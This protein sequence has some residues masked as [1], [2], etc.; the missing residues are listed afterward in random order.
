MGA[1]LLVHPSDVLVGGEGCPKVLAD[2]AVSVDTG[3]PIPR[4]AELANARPADGRDP[5]PVR[6][7]RAEQ[8]F[9]LGAVLDGPL[10]FNPG[11]EKRGACGQL[12][13]RVY[14][15]GRGHPR[16]LYA[17]PRLQLG[18]PARH[19]RRVVDE[20]LL[21]VRR[22]RGEPQAEAS[23]EKQKAEGAWGMAEGGIKTECADSWKPSVSNTPFN[24]DGKYRG[25][26]STGS[27]LV[28][29]AASGG[30]AEHLLSS[31]LS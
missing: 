7:P 1:V 30:D 28:G 19:A 15:Q 31:F 24:Q 5:D 14:A 27:L 18:R 10:V 17:V 29:T 22:G 16:L 9:A 4:R 12:Q 2:D 8:Q 6:Q 25:S 20:H 26:F 23:K 13:G 3:R 21:C 11:C